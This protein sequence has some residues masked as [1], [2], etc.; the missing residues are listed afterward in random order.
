MCPLINAH[1][2]ELLRLPRLQ[3]Q[4]NNI[5]LL[6]NKMQLARDFVNAYTALTFCRAYFLE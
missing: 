6:S 2:M 1:L 5:G 4:I 3:K